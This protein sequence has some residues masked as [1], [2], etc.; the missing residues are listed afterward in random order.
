MTGGY[1]KGGII[2][3]GPAGAVGY[4]PDSDGPLI[5]PAAHDR[6]A[7]REVDRLNRRAPVED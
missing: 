7:R 2:Q 5:G 1:A 3:G 4:D 6:W